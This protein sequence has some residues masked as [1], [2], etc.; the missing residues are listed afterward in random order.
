MPASTATILVV[1]DDARNRKLLETLLNAE[2]YRVICADSGRAALDAALAHTPDLVLLDLMMPDL[3]GFDVVRRMRAEPSVKS[4]PLVVV[5]ALDDPGSNARLASVGVDGVLHKP[6]D[7]W[8]VRATL[9][10]VLGGDA[11]AGS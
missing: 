8:A 2:G 11:G 1:D 7:R 4:V 5:T 10:R 9:G 3:D 6:I